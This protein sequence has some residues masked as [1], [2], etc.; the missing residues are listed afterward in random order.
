MPTPN[1]GIEIQSNRTW[2]ILPGELGPRKALE[3]AAQKLGVG[4]IRLAGVL[5][6]RVALESI[7]RRFSEP[8]ELNRPF[9]EHLSLPI[10]ASDFLFF[11]DDLLAV[12]PRLLLKNQWNFLPRRCETLEYSST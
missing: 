4:Q 5:I 7:R 9:R 3:I 8:Q 6:N 10:D 12:D 11:L 1:D 2:E